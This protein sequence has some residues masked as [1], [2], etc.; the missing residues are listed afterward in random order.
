MLIFCGI[1][2][3][4]KNYGVTYKIKCPV[5]EIEKYYQFIRTSIF[6]HFFRIPVFPLSIRYYNICP[7]CNNA[8]QIRGKIK[9]KYKNLSIINTKFLNGKI[10]K[11]EHKEATNL[12]E[13]TE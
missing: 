9:D 12:I 2:Q 3:M 5:C 13:E 7:N 6:L 11:S 10:T 1:K 4:N 8:I